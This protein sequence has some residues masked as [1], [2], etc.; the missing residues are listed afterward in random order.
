ME[1][2]LRILKNAGLEKTILKENKEQMNEEFKNSYEEG[3]RVM[4]PMGPGTILRTG[5]DD[6]KHERYV[7][8]LVRLDHSD[9]P[10]GDVFHLEPL[11]HIE[12]EELENYS[13]E[14]Y[15][16]KL[17]EFMKMD[18]AAGVGINAEFNTYPYTPDIKKGT[19]KKTGKQLGFD[20]TDGGV[21]PKV[22]KDSINK[23]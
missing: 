4:T 2:L 12:N 16:M 8:P 23:D 15:T 9:D 19:L 3:D 7:Q 17:K 22:S 14:N 20:I 13:I 21:P 1:D 6:L 5:Y 10:E 11:R 18:E